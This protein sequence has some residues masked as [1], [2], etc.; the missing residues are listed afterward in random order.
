[1]TK[2]ILLWGALVCLLPSL[3]DSFV[4]QTSCPSTIILH[5]ASS[6]TSDDVS[7]MRVKEIKDELEE[8]GIDYTDCFDKESMVSR[9]V[10]ARSGKVQAEVEEKPKVDQKKGGGGGEKDKQEE[11]AASS[12]SPE[13]KTI[14]NDFDMDAALEELRGMR[15]R[16]LREE[17]GRRQISRA[18][19]FEKEDLIQ[20]LL[21]AREQASNFSTTGLCMPGQVA[22]LTGDELDQEMK[23]LSTPLLVDIYATWCGP[24]QMVSKSSRKR[25][26]GRE[27]ILKYISLT[28][29]LFSIIYRWLHN[30]NRQLLILEIEFE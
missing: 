3:S 20:A 6:P 2:W 15:V 26:I 9:L 27:G 25:D 21:K 7:S 24:C 12:S 18:G 23:H 11:P 8:R 10:D 17:L 4:I 29:F 5:S 19:L 13:T 16:E 1:M 30:C 22:D 14:V 28:L